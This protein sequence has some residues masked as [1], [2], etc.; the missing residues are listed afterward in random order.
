MNNI[1][2][3]YS[4]IVCL[5]KYICGCRLYKILILVWLYDVEYNV[6]HIMLITQEYIR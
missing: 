6:V 5:Y 1:M 3:I 2:M 4:H